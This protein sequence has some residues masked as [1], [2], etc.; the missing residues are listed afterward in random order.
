LRYFNGRCRTG[1]YQNRDCLYI[2]SAIG[3]EKVI[4]ISGGGKAGDDKL[5][6]GNDYG[7]VYIT[8]A[9]ECHPDFIQE[10]FDRTLASSYPF[11]AHD[12]NPKP[13]GHWYYEDVLAH[14]EKQQAENPG[15]GFNYGNFTIVDNLSVT[16]EQ[17]RERLKRYKKGSIWYLRDIKGQRKQA[18]GLVFPEFN[19]EIHIKPTVER[20]YSECYISIDYGTSHPCVF[21]LWGE[22]DGVWY[23]VK[24]YVYNGSKNPQKTANEYYA[25]LLEFSKG[26]KIK[27][28][29]LDNAPISSSFNVLVRRKG[30]FN[31][32]M[33]DNSVLQGCQDVSMAFQAQKIFINDCC[34]CLIK[35]IGLYMW[36]SKS[37]EEAPLKGNDDETDCMRYFVRTKRIAEQRRK[38]LVSAYKDK[39]VC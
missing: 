28:L 11:V 35:G 16:D 15:Y 5:I 38:G 31:T 3:F 32:R 34:V 20:A 18:D 13:E 21:Q 4:L 7:V 19:S 12:N 26:Y 1:K 2:Y 17:L 33:S 39:G 36:D 30:E 6:K 22:C 10:T 24:E 9:N 23:C 37:D 14:H 29:Y 27:Q 25:D 8:E